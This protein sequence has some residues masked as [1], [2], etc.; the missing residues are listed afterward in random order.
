MFQVSVNSPQNTWQV[1][2]SHPRGLITENTSKAFLSK[3]W[4]GGHSYHQH[5]SGQTRVYAR[6]PG[7]E[8]PPC[9]LEAL[10]PQ[11]SCFA[12]LILFTHL[13]RGNTNHS[14]FK[15]ASRVSQVRKGL[16]GK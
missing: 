10:W 2:P 13:N 5:E 1:A 8:F 16:E 15:E 7:F 11:T 3:A 6:W 9:H 14:V 4:Q 12:A